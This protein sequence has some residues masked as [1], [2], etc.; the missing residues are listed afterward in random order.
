[1]RAPQ[2]NAAVDIYHSTIGWEQ[3]EVTVNTVVDVANYARR[4]DIADVDI[5]KGSQRR[6]GCSPF[7][8]GT[9]SRT[10]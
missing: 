1:M 4:L 9:G 5:Q 10:I 7:V 2:A 8:A 6:V 3:R